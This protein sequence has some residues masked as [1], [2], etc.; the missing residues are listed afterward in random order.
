MSVIL[1][2]INLLFPAVSDTL[3]LKNGFIVSG[4]LQV[5][6]A[7]VVDFYFDKYDKIIEVEKSDINYIKSNEKIIKYESNDLFEFYD[8]IWWSIAVISGIIGIFILASSL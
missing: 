6:R 7:D 1:L 2:F 3:F 4:K 5:E 8:F